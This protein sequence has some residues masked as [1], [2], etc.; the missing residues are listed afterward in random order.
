MSMFYVFSLFN[1]LIISINFETQTSWSICNDP[2]ANSTV[3]TALAA[4]AFVE[5]STNFLF[6]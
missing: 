1:K 2:T 4:D 5:L 6:V 3:T